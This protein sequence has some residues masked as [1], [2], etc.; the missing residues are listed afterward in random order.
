[1][2]GIKKGCDAESVS[3]EPN[4]RG[5]V[6]ARSVRMTGKRRCV[7]VSQRF[8]PDKGGNA[9]RIHDMT[10]HLNGRDWDATVLAPPPS[11]PPGEFD[12]SFR[13]KRTETRDGVTVHRL[14]AWQ[15]QV[16][17][18][19]TVRRLAYYLTFGLHAMLWLLWHV[20]RYDAVVITTPPISTGA[21]GLLAALLGKPW[22]VDVR[23]LWIDASV[24]LGY[25]EAGSALERVSRRFQRS[26]LHTAD[27]IAVTTETLGA[28]L[29]ETYGESLGEKTFHLPNGVDT[30]RFRPGAEAG[31]ATVHAPDGNVAHADGHGGAVAPDPAAKPDGGE[32]TIV[33][34]GNLGSAQDLESCIRAM[35]H[36]SDETA[37]L[38][39]V[40]GGDLE[41]DLKQLTERQGLRDRVEYAGAVPREEI[42]EILREATVGVAPLRDTEELAY[43]MPTKVYEYLASGLPALVTGRGEV[44]QFVEDSG[45]GVWADNDPEQVAAR[46]DELLADAQLRRRLA[47]D[48][49]EHVV[50][51]YDRKG[52]ARRLGA[53]LTWLVEDQQ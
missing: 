14:W 51:N 5:A 47:A 48:G 6:A 44:K 16:E 22:V 32:P 40:G 45:G 1:M 29:Q 42:P 43:A 25:L 12:R 3:N 27:R 4:A 8:P 46:L 15:P 37:V 23:D 41:S 20:R 18:P 13:R 35:S 28:S 19:G 31:G 39:L 38:R 53:E 50:A 11:Y 26:V 36:L 9:A 10:A 7:F 30:D 33:Y 52:L 34:T 21:P 2:M 17:N 49:R 24:S